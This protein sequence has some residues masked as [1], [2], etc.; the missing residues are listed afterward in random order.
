[1]NCRFF[2]LLALLA[3][4]CG[5]EKQTS[6]ST[7]GQPI[8]LAAVLE[9]DFQT[10]VPYTQSVPST[11][12]P[13]RVDVWAST[14]SRTFKDEGKNGRGETSEVAIHTKGNFQSGAPQLLSQ[15]VYPPPKAGNNAEKVYF[16]AMHPQSIDN[17]SKWDTSDGADACFTFSGCE[18]LMFAPEVSGAYDIEEQGQV[19]K[20]SPTLF[21]EHLLT[22]FTIRMGIVLGEGEN[23]QDVQEAWGKVV[24][25]GIQS[26]NSTSLQYE[27]LDK[28]TID[29]SK[30][31]G[32]SDSNPGGF[33]FD[34][35]VKFSEEENSASEVMGFYIIGAD[36][37]FPGSEGYTLTDQVD[38]VAYVMCAP[39]VAPEVSGEDSSYEYKIIL[40]TEQRGEMEF[41]LD[42]QKSGTDGAAVPFEGSTR[43]KHFVVTL[44]FKKGRAVVNAVN[45][46]QWENGGFGTGDITD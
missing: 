25:L 40:E 31:A 29:L 12:N 28:V 24:A 14:V 44:K 21:F 37:Q 36:V 11:E 38:S 30:G 3:F 1:M 17:G 26:Y 4:L 8:Y 16:V 33:D 10:K 7:D 43:G 46:A 42:L 19:V 18:D 2:I 13:L 32:K 15:A 23:L 41:E 35:D 27:K 20:D 5:C 6:C 22:R 39:V 45:V 34:R 9:N